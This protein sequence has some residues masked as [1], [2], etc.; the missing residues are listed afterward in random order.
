MIDLTPSARQRFDDYLR[1]LRQ[2][3]R[4]ASPSEADDVEQSVREHIEVALAGV[5]APVGGEQLAEVLD[6]L[7]APDG[8]VPA[9]DRSIVRRAIQQVTDRLRYGPEEWRLAY[10]TFGLF[11][12]ALLLMPVGIGF[13]LMIASF[14]A[15]RAYVDFMETKQEA[16]GARRWLIYPPIGFFLAVA[17][18]FF[19]VG[20]AG[21]ALGWGIGDHGFLRL[22]DESRLHA[23]YYEEQF[24]A[25]AVVTVLGTWWILASLIGMAFL[26]VIRFIF[27]PLLAR[28]RRAHFLGLTLVGALS[29]ALGFVLLRPWISQI[30]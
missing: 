19:V 16:P 27:K 12:L 26:P 4:R 17:T 6:R 3:L 18:A 2:S 21:P 5:P 8:W 20:L 22:L 24:V 13:F 1:R 25:G 29:V 11:L 23:P 14:L 10:V 28:V 9:D 7:G 30:W 15:S